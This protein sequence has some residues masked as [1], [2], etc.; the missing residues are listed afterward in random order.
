MAC[1]QSFVRRHGMPGVARHFLTTP[2]CR[3]V[4]FGQWL[5]LVPPE[6]VVL[7]K[8]TSVGQIF[9][10]ASHDWTREMT[11]SR[12]MITSIGVFLQ[13]YA[14]WALLTRSLVWPLIWPSRP[15]LYAAAWIMFF[16]G[17]RLI[18]AML[19]SEF[20]RK[21]QL[22][23]DETAAR[24]IQRTLQPEVLEQRPGFQIQ[25]FYRPFRA[26]GGDYFDVIDLPGNRI[27]IALADVSGKGIAAALLAS[28]IQALV[29][30]I[31]VAEADLVALAS[32]VNRHLGR[33]TPSDRFATAVFLVL[34]RESSEITYVN[35]GHNPPLLCGSGP[36]KF[37]DATGLP[38]G[39]FANA[40]Y[41]KRL[42]ILAAGDTLLI[43]T[44]GL[45]DSISG[46]SPQ[47]RLRSAVTDDSHQ[48]LSNLK[49][50][51]DPKLN[52]DD[53]TVVLA[54]RVTAGSTQV[55][56]SANAAGD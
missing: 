31:A 30:S 32:Q 19:T 47:D 6:E 50:L 16:L 35:A 11:P 27:L 41:E 26:V 52:E 39:L 18:N 22:E 15:F 29:R 3:L 17:H 55:L 7:E 38:L 20:L 37:L 25:A 1:P 49:A 36:T 28:N 45:T 53:V 8:H 46:D 10:Y 5:R 13:G 4:D 43:Y 56:T 9:R 54:K 33:Y 23:A 24:A 42:A 14:F 48:S 44:D 40:T 34:S 51:I 12:R 21:S 2:L